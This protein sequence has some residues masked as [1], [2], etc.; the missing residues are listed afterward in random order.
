MSPQ[1]KQ[2]LTTTSGISKAAA[3][4]RKGGDAVIVVVIRAE[5]VAFSVDPRV[6]PR[7]AVD[8]VRRELPELLMH[9]Q[10][11]RDKKGANRG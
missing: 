11:E 6:A 3:W 9:L 7:D 2:D 8:L 4:L 1:N 10:L 5:D